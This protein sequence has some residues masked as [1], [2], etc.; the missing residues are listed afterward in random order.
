MVCDVQPSVGYMHSGYPVVTHLDI[1]EVQ[2]KEFVMNSTRLRGE[3]W[4]GL[5]HELGH[6]MQEDTWTFEGTTEVTCN[7][8]TLHAMEA[9]SGQKPWIHSWLQGQLSKTYSY[10]RNGADF[11]EWKDS[12][13]VALFVYAQLIQAFGWSSFKVNINYILLFL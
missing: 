8:F 2:S 3:G 9:V 13:G 1:T 4:W 7:I 10:L 6:N 5:Y 12:P 11:E